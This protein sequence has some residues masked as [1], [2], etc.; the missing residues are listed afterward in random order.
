M[1]VEFQHHE[2][3]ILAAGDTIAFERN[4][5]EFLPSAGWQLQYQVRGGA[6][7][8]IG[9]APVEFYSTP[10]ATNT[11]HQITVADNV[12]ALWAP[13]E[14]ILSGYAVNAGTNERKEIYNNALIISPNLNSPADNVNVKTYA[15]EMIEL[16]ECTYKQL[17]KSF[18]LETNIQQTQVIRQKRAEI[19]QELLFWYEKRANEVAVQNVKNGR[20]SGNKIKP[21][22]NVLSCGPSIGNAPSWPFAQP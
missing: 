2:P 6:G 19:R 21:V 8:Q 17:S 18:L 10:D 9:Q 5:P 11:L 1:A 7:Q 12:T 14:Y 15:Q 3:L 4:L 13:G 20:P 16:Y 22:F